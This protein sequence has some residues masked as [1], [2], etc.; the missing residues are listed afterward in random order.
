MD[1]YT[2]GKFVGDKFTPRSAANTS[3][4]VRAQRHEPKDS[5]DFF[6]TNPWATRA[7]VEKVMKPLGLFHSGDR[8]WEPACGRGHMVRALTEY[9]S[10][11]IRSDIYDH[12]EDA[13]H[14][15]S[16]KFFLQ[17]FL[18]V[19]S[20]KLVDWVITN[21]PFN[22]LQ[23]FIDKALEVAEM[24]VAIFGPLTMLES[25]GRYE[26]IFK[27]YEGHFTAAPFVERCPTNKGSPKK[28]AVTAT[29]YAW[30]LICPQ[31]N[32]RPLV[33][34][35]PCRKELERDDDYPEDTRI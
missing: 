35:P 10:K 26:K 27:P 33:H 2:P 8:V 28:N 23:P 18:D 29:A 3:H 5:L 30:L 20:E 6:G 19:R 7:L 12:G 21:P 11:V 32:M 4:A 13:T 14:G 15:S 25:V 17:N 16:Y 34:T 1:L 22:A 31:A 9:Y 24:G